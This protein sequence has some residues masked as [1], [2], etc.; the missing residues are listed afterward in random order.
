VKLRRQI[1]VN[2][3]ATIEQDT[4]QCGF[5]GSKISILFLSLVFET[6]R[7]EWRSPAARPAISIEI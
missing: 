1:F 4:D 2:S 5:S 6:D 3:Y 7:I